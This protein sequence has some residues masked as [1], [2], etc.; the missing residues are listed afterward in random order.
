MLA[1]ITMAAAKW[2]Y[3]SSNNS[4]C[5]ECK[6]YANFYFVSHNVCAKNRNKWIRIW[7][8]ITKKLDPNKSIPIIRFIFGKLVRIH[9]SNFFCDQCFVH[10]NCSSYHF[11]IVASFI[12]AWPWCCT[13]NS[14]GW[15]NVDCVN[16]VHIVDP[17][18]YLTGYLVR[19][20]FNFAAKLKCGVFG[21]LE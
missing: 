3:K 1:T 9:Y 14:C 18:R 5:D 8:C 17:I 4:K 6:C 15:T 21:S 19:I 13:C 2:K 12:L 7:I 10:P 20:W 16:M 11:S